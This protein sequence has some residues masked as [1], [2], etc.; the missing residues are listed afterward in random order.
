M[1][2]FCRGNDAG[3]YGV[4]VYWPMGIESKGCHSRTLR[5]G[6]VICVF[7]EALKNH[8]Q[9]CQHVLLLAAPKCLPQNL[10]DKTKFDLWCILDTYNDG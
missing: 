7:L 6:T 5:G 3:G 1:S 9:A 4:S 8:T 2:A 10:C